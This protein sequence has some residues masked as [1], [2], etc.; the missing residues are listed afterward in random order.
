VRQFRDR[1]VRITE[2]D[3]FFALVDEFFAQVEQHHQG[4]APAV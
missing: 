2:R 4:A 1:F 3:A